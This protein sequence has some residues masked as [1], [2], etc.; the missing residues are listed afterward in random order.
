MRTKF[1]AA[2]LLA[3]SIESKGICFAGS[4]C[5]GISRQGRDAQNTLSIPVESRAR[6][7]GK[8]QSTPVGFFKVNQILRNLFAKPHCQKTLAFASPV[9]SW[10]HKPAR[11][12]K[13]HQ[14]Q[15]FDDAQAQARRRPQLHSGACRGAQIG[16]LA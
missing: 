14:D 3:K 16:L 11:H 9:P 15:G 13:A 4:L 5:G 8:P 12:P 1:G 2:N 10:G 6:E 7:P